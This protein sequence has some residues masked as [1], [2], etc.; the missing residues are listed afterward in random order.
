MPTTSNNRCSRSRF[1]SS[2]ETGKRRST[3]ISSLSHFNVA[4]LFH[5]QQI[6]WSVEH[7]WSHHPLCCSQLTSPSIGGHWASPF[8]HCTFHLYSMRGHRQL[9]T[10][11]TLA[12]SSTWNSRQL[13]MAKICEASQ[14]LTD[15]KWTNIRQFQKLKV[16][17]IGLQGHLSHP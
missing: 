14:A 7:F 9:R 15:F 10:S 16:K 13:D 12:A 4:D 11:S 17:C 8:F 6:C 1:W 3:V 5:S 2:I